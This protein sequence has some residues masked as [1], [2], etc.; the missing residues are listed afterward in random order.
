MAAIIYALSS[1]RVVYCLACVGQSFCWYCVWGC[2]P[3]KTGSTRLMRDILIFDA[4][5]DTP[6]YFV[7]EGYRLADEHGYYEL[8]IPRMKKGKLG[9][10]LFG[11]YV[12]PQDY[13][14]QLWLPRSC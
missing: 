7:D 6:R 1:G 3:R 8:D 10:V 12:Q 14:P 9:A 2:F 11:I 4:H 13:P 5:I